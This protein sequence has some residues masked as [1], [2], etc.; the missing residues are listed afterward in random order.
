VHAL[1]TSVVTRNVFLA[2][3][4]DQVTTLRR[5]LHQNGAAAMRMAPL[6]V[7]PAVGQQCDDADTT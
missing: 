6:Q 1:L 2:D 7:P 5:W 3:L 4:S